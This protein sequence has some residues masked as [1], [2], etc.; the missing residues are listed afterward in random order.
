[1]KTNGAEALAFD[2]IVASGPNSS[3]PHAIPGNRKIEKKDI[4]QLDFGCKVN[5][6][7]SDF[8]RVIFVGEATKEEKNVYNF[9]VKEQK[10]IIN[11]L[12]DGLNIKEILKESEEHYSSESY[13]ILHSF[14]HGL[15]LDVHEEPVLS[16][17]YETKLK[18][19]M[20]VTVE[21]G[22]YIPG[23]FGIRIEDTILINKND[24]SSLTESE[25]NI[26]ILKI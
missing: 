10:F 9:V 8:S 24:A 1:M 13:E 4:I 3:M 16:S 18:K 5:G 26:C 2:T 25:K 20:L 11:N 12:K 21:P 7:S 23:Q 14:G 22:V 17:R 6:Y 19:N 15:G